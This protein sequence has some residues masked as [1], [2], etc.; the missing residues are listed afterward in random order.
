[1][2]NILSQTKVA[3]LF[4]ITIIGYIIF[5]ANTEPGSFSFRLTKYNSE[6]WALWRYLVVGSWLLLAY[7]LFIAQSKTAFRKSFTDAII[8]SGFVSF[9]LVII[10]L[11]YISKIA[12]LGSAITYT[13]IAGLLCLTLKNH[14]QA[15]IIAPIL[16]IAQIIVDIFVLGI[17][18]DFRIH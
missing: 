13:M 16:V 9:V 3:G 2:N 14:L 11:K 6:T 5:S 15:R 17:A 10:W 8:S 4:L 1:M 12:I 7:L 18:G